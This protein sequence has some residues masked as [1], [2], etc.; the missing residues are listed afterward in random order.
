MHLHGD[1]RDLADAVGTGEKLA[2]IGHVTGGASLMADLYHVTAAVAFVD[3]AHRLGLSY[4]QCHRFFE[5]DVLARRDRIREL[6]GVQMLGGGDD[7]GVHGRIVQQTAVIAM[8]RRAGR[9][10]PQPSPGAWNKRRQILRSQYWSKPG[11]D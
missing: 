7:H 3:R 4:A 5:I 8:D 9:Y 11:Y 2:N 6:L 1:G 10:G